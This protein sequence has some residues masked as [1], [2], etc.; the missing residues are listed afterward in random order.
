MHLLITVVMARLMP[1]PGMQW[2]PAMVPPMALAVMLAVPSVEIKLKSIILPSWNIP[3]SIPLGMPSETIFLRI[4]FSTL[5]LNSSRIFKIYFLFS[6]SPKIRNA[7]IHLETSVGMATPSTPHFRPKM[8]IA[9]PATLMTFISMDV[10]S[11]ILVM[12]I[13]RNRAAPAL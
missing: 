13:A 4:C 10:F 9:L 5:N 8:R 7:A 6:S 2:N 1:N 11:V 12:P 3:F